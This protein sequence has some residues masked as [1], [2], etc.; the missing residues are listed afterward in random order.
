M[1]LWGGSWYRYRCLDVFELGRYSQN[2]VRILP[3]DDKPSAAPLF[4]DHGH[5]AVAWLA[6]CAVWI[7][8]RSI[9]QLQ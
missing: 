8:M 1:R 2:R 7:L 6:W 5:H 9:L 3:Y 4:S